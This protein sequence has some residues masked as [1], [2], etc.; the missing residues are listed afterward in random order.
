VFKAKNLPQYKTPSPG[1]VLIYGKHGKK[2]ADIA[3]M[4]TGI[5][6]AEIIFYN[7]KWVKL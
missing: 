1:G 5:D 6:R 3:D 7:V 4:G 2:P